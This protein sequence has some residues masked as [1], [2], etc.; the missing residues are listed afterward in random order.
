MDVVALRHLQDDDV[1]VDR[2]EVAEGFAELVHLLVFLRDEVAPVGVE[3]EAH[4]AEDA[5]G[6]DDE[7]EDG[8]ALAV[9]QTEERE[10]VE[11]SVNQRKRGIT[12]E[13]DR[14]KL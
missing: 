3:A 1:V 5:E 9:P 13:G 11:E 8:D 4:G 10:R 12:C 6:R 14:V 7:G 2:A